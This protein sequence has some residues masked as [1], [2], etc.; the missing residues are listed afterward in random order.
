MYKSIF[1]T[2]ILNGNYWV[3]TKPYYYTEDR[4]GNG[5]S[6]YV[7][8]GFLIQTPLLPPPLRYLFNSKFNDCVVMLIYLKETKSLFYKKRPFTIEDRHIDIVFLDMLRQKGYPPFLLPVVKL[9][10][11]FYNPVKRLS[12]AYLLRKNAVEFYIR[13]KLKL[14][15]YYV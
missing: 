4:E 13:E 7:P 14:D 12:P 9:V 10:L 8:N 15:G 11:K 5:F 2:S 6:L 3:T 1:A